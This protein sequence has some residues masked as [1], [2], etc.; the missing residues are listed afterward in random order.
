MTTAIASLG[1]I[2]RVTLGDRVYA[3]L[4]ELLMGG[5]LAPGEKLS[6][7]RVSE[8]M[9]VSMMPVRE[10]VTRLVADAA[11]E[12]LPN[13]SVSVPILTLAQFRELTTVRLA[14]EGFAAEQAALH[15][16][17]EDLRAM[18]GFEAA[19]N[20]ESESAKPDSARAVHANKDL[21]FST[22]RASRLPT[23]VAIIEG[24]W[25]K[26][27]PILNFDLKMSPERLRTG[28]AREQHARL[29]AAVAARDGA[30]ARA[31]LVADVTGTAAFIEGTG[32][33]LD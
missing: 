28:G 7:R 31:A 1:R 10:A 23:L 33:L 27:G 14:I 21:H 5:D 11:L 8:M 18:R 3:E 30:A 12:V 24:L 32:R 6:L 19:F 22:Y 17:E 13:R 4:R 9:G 16:R 2:E 25:L 15:R 29:V 20:R 26:I